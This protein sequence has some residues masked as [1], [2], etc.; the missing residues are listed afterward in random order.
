MIPQYIKQQCK[1]LAE[2]YS[3]P[4]YLLDIEKI[5]SKYEEL[6]SQ[7][8]LYFP[9]L[10]VAYSYKTNSLGVITR[11]LG[12]LGSCAEVVSGAEL[13]YALNDGFSPDRIFFDGPVKTKDELLYALSLGVTVQVDS[14]DELRLIITLSQEN[15]FISPNVSCRLAT[16]YKGKCSRFGLTSEE[17]HIARK[18]LLQA[19]IRLAGIHIHLGSNISSP[20]KHIRAFQELKC[21]FREILNTDNNIF[22]D[23]GGGYPARTLCE[24]FEPLSPALYAEYIAKYFTSL[25]IDCDNLKLV[26]EPG[27]CLVEDEGYLVTKVV[28][29]KVRNQSNLIIV[30]AGTNLVRSI[31]SW[32]HLAEFI[33]YSNDVDNKAKFDIF[34]SNCFESDILFRDFTTSISTNIND[35][36]II[37]GCGG[38]D[39]PSANI[40]TRPSP[41][42]LT[43]AQQGAVK[44]ARVGQLVQDMRNM[45]PDKC[46]FQFTEH[47]Y[48][49]DKYTLRT[50]KVDDS[51]ALFD[52]VNKNRH[53]LGKW[54]PWVDFTKHPD[55]SKSFIL[56]EEKARLL[57]QRISYAICYNTLPIGMIAFH[58]IDWAN[59]QATVGYW[60]SSEWEGKGIV[61]R[62]CIQLFNYGFSS[63][64]LKKIIIKCATG[65]IKSRKIPEKLGFLLE[66][67]LTQVEKVNN[68]FLDHAVYG[69]TL[70]QWKHVHRV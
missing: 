52:S 5:Y 8:K 20:E 43:L 68:I 50:L 12:K 39:I 44:I 26:I 10:R 24:G 45:E 22:I 38:Y 57:G 48:I 62:A 21:I 55:D 17:F 70:E 14:L 11:T 58:E 47:I 42:I 35:L 3:T 53:H 18:M 13:E 60:I 37:S 65:N 64:N 54:L 31:N 46:Q 16:S 36:L 56:S 4:F 28:V 19:D 41:P 40:W 32:H 9:Q 49:D 61:S 67:V 30:D 15:D 33:H 23:I 25:D 27:R 66:G 59:E 51:Q 7:W 34:G 29:K 2:N 6:Q 69:V 1:K 63:L